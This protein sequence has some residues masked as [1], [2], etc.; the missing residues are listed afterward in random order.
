[1][2]LAPTSP[3]TYWTFSPVYPAV[4]SNLAGGKTNSSSCSPNSYLLLTS[5]I[6]TQPAKPATLENFAQL[7]HLQN[8]SGHCVFLN[9]IP[10][11][12]PPEGILYLPSP[13]HNYH[14]IL[15]FHLFLSG[16]PAGV[17][18]PPF[19]L[20]QWASSVWLHLALVS[21][22]SIVPRGG[23]RETQPLL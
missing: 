16:P 22:S 17:S 18:N 1:M 23:W 19:T 14:H 7:H 4:T 2:D 20:L 11:P 10:L 3:I 8:A 5:L 15:G 13:S 9:T 21:S 6:N 12:Y